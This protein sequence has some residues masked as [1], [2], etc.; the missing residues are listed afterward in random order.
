MGKGSSSSSTSQATT[1]ET[2]TISANNQGVA[3]GPGSSY[4]NDLSP[5]AVSIVNRA[6]DFSSGVLSQGQQ[7][8]SDALVKS[9]NESLASQNFAASAL[10]QGQAT[11]LAA[12]NSAQLG[13]T[14]ILTNPATLIGIVAVLGI[15]AYI[16]LKRRG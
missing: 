10:A 16:T 6:F 7:I 11:N 3:I 8:L 14:S 4:V 1:S 12:L 13:Q 2:S 15:I 9:A 5:A